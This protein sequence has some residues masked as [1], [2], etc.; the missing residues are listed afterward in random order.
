M[1]NRKKNLEDEYFSLIIEKQLQDVLSG[2]GFEVN[3]VAEVV[4]LG[5]KKKK[6]LVNTTTVMLRRGREFYMTR[7]IAAIIDFI[8]TPNPDENNLFD[9]IYNR[10]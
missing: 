7:R 6:L 8:F 10:V 4:N 1:L 5:T 3:C 2:L 9:I